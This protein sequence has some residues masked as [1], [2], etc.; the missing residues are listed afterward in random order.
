MLIKR[1]DGTVLGR[2]TLDKYGR[3]VLK[4]NPSFILAAGATWRYI[5]TPKVG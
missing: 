4:F 5:R 3:R 1:Q 2:Y